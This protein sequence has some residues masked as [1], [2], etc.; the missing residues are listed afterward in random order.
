MAPNS[1]Q[2]LLDTIDTANTK[3]SNRLGV[4]D[5]HIDAII[6]SG[7]A[8]LVK[9]KSGVLLPDQIAQIRSKINS[10]RDSTLAN[11]GSKNSRISEV[12]KVF[13]ELLGVSSPE[14]VAA[15]KVSDTVAKVPNRQNLLNY[16][17]VEDLFSSASN[18]PAKYT[19]AKG[20]PNRQ[21]LLNYG[22]V[23]E[24]FS[25]GSNAPAKYTVAKGEP[26]R[27]NLLNYGNVGDLFS[28]APNAPAK[29]TVAKGEANR[30]RKNLLNYGNV[31]ELFSSAPNA[32]AKYT[33]AKGEANRN[34]KNLLNYGNV[35]ELFSSASNAPAKYTV[36][37]G[38][39]NR[40]RKNLLNYG[41]VGELFSSASNAP[42]KYTVATGDDYE[43]D[44]FAK[45][46]QKRMNIQA[47]VNREKT[48]ELQ[49]QFQKRLAVLYAIDAIPDSNEIRNETHVQQITDAIEAIRV[50]LQENL[51]NPINAGLLEYLN[52]RYSENLR[53][54][55]GEMKAK[56]KPVLKYIVS[57]AG[58]LIYFTERIQRP[59]GIFL[60]ADLQ[61]R[62]SIL[63]AVIAS[64]PEENRP[65][66]KGYLNTLYE[67][68]Q[69]QSGGKRKTRCGCG[70]KGGR[71]TRKTSRRRR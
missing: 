54:L 43:K 70:L 7:K 14:K 44:Q 35:G 34:R 9:I 42:A 71:R 65:N 19:V 38:E 27:Q 13:N 51:Q 66:L 25:S 4:L 53:S 31:G 33:V 30:N 17:N 68:R 16:G 5:T 58:D 8:L 2:E 56:H 45:N 28:S 26:N 48:Q 21:N 57:L 20:V 50:L 62:I 1:F 15:A 12:E 69:K 10:L 39:P 3:I 67:E 46:I 24:L 55:V 6:N 41:N 49:K 61:E 63:T 52:Q 36:A 60:K 18:A 11:I 32:P 29:Y 40:N 23:G 37:K 64:L 47:S 22:N 59:I